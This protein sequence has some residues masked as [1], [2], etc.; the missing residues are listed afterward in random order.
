MRMSV[1]R[2]Q[3]TAFSRLLHWTMAAMILTMLCI[4]VTMVAS[5]ANY[6]WLISIHRPL[7][8]SEAEFPSAVSGHDVASRASGGNCVG[9]HDVR[10]DVRFAAGRVG[11]AI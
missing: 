2:R 5:L 6:H 8:E 1:E 10:S 11:N 9:I 7:C 3:F 4:G